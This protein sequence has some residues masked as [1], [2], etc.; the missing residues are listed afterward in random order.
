M[1]LFGGTGNSG[2]LI[3][4]EASKKNLTLFLLGI[5]VCM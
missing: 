1:L 3:K 2:S 5:I 4:K